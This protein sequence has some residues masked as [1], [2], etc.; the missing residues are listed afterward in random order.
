LFWWGIIHLECMLDWQTVDFHWIFALNTSF[1]STNYAA[2]SFGGSVTLRLASSHSGGNEMRALV[3]VMSAKDPRDVI[4]QA[5]MSKTNSE[6]SANV[7][8]QRIKMGR[9]WIL[10]DGNTMDA[11]AAE[12]NRINGE[13]TLGSNAKL[14][15]RPADP[16]PPHGC[17]KG[18]ICPDDL[19]A[20]A[21][22]ALTPPTRAPSTASLIVWV[23]PSKNPTRP[24]L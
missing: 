6:T 19:L 13:C 11:A 7:N 18:V 15:G 16:T 9:R 8:W 1:N 10:K 2:I 23:M 20:K 4:I 24:Q 21:K 12:A 3:N 14:H 5:P 22:V 17:N